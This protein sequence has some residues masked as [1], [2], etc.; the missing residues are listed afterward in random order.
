M[1][2]KKTSTKASPKPDPLRNPGDRTDEPGRKPTDNPG[3]DSHAA[4]EPI[5]QKP[6]YGQ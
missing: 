1:A 4:D 3:R 2:D 6:T 5:E